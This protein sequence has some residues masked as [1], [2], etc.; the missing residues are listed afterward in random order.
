[1]PKVVPEYKEQARARIVDAAAQVFRRK[2][3]PAGTMDEIAREIGVS[4]GAL[5]LYFP[6]K[7]R[8]LEAVQ[9]RFRD[10][11][12]AVLEQRL[13]H[14]DVAQ[15]IVDSIDGIFSGEFDPAVFHQLV[16]TAAADPEVRD[17]LRADARGDRRAFRSLLTRLEAEGRIPPMAD[18]EATADAFFLLLHGAFSSVSLHADPT[19]GRRQ[20]L[21]ALRLVLGSSTRARGRSGTRARVVRGPPSEVPRPGA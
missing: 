10:Q 9:A 2:G 15:G 3:L 4:K 19:E 6:T 1:M 16:M 20:L 14:G 13:A 11:Y 18:P 21:R 12:V 7:A 5:Y 8:L 17:A